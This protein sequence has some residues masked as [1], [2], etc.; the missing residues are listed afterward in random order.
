MSHVPIFELPSLCCASR[1]ESKEVN[2]EA[3]GGGDEKE[4]RE[5]QHPPPNLVMRFT[6]FAFRVLNHDMDAFFED[7]MSEFE[8]EDGEL[9]SG[10][11]ETLG[12]YEVYRQYIRELERHFDGYAILYFCLTLECVCEGDR[13]HCFKI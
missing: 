1:M 2:N 4:G 8:Q 9:S 12:Q 10:A 6:E 5:L 3:K 13:M 7:S 11:G